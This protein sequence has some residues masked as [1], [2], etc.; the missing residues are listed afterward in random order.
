V[1]SYI[2]ATA[3]PGLSYCDVLADAPKFLRLMV[4]VADDNWKGHALDGAHISCSPDASEHASRALDGYLTKVLGVAAARE[5]V[6]FSENR[7][8]VEQEDPVNVQACLDRALRA[9]TRH[10]SVRS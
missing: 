3:A 10:S 6:F 2:R 4:Y 8:R 5:H 7:E 1:E 9:R